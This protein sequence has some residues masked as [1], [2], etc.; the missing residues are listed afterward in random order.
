M[1]FA[2]DKQKIE[3]IASGS[4]RELSELYKDNIAAELSSGFQSEEL[5]P[6]SVLSKRDGALSLERG[7]KLVWSEEIELKIT[8]T[9]PATA[10]AGFLDK[11]S[12]T[13]HGETVQ[14]EDVMNAFRS[15]LSVIVKRSSLMHLL[16]S[17]ITGNPLTTLQ[18]ALDK[19]TKFYKN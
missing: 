9:L 11:M 2:E 18:Y 14:S 19:M 10:K 6:D 7:R 13:K 8:K 15:A 4:F 16:S 1:S 3:K 5:K 17:A 12:E